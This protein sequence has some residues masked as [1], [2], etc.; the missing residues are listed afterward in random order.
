MVWEE[1]RNVRRKTTHTGI[2]K[3]PSRDPNCGNS[4]PLPAFCFFCISRNGWKFLTLVT[5]IC[6]TDRSALLLIAVGR[7]R[8]VNSGQSSQHFKWWCF[9]FL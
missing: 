9:F 7:L 8:N 5:Q 4:K 6:I 3:R 2:Q 1:R